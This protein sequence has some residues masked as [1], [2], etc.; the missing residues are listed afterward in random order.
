MILHGNTRGGAKQ[1]ALHLM[2]AEDN[3]YVELHDLK[4]FAA[5][6]VQ[7]AFREVQAIARGTR[8]KQFL[9]SLSL[10][11]PPSAAV[12]HS[13]FEEAIR[14]IEDQLRLSGQPRVI[15]FHE[16]EGRRHC[17]AVWSRIDAAS[18]KAINLP[19]T[20]TKLRGISQDLFQRHGWRMP[21][22]LIDHERKSTMNYTHNEHQQAKRTRQDLNAL[23]LQISKIYAASADRTDFA[24]AV[25]HKGFSLAKGDQRDFVLVDD[26]GEVY[27]LPRLA[28]NRTRDVRAKFGDNDGLPTIEE[29]H[30][31]IAKLA[32]QKKSTELARAKE[33]RQAIEKAYKEERAVLIAQHRE[34]RAKLVQ[35]QKE[36]WQ[37]ESLERASRYRKGILGLWDRMTGRHAEI[38][39]QNETEVE[40]S[41]RRDEREIAKLR[42]H[43]N[44]LLGRQ[45]I[46][47]RNHNSI[48]I[49]HQPVGHLH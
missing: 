26:N 8:C 40:F 36:R 16:K 28:C 1:L 47:L 5:N 17:H 25:E 31:R 41:K 15:V 34:E 43:Q 10:S 19:Y 37:Q 2:N 9:Y 29:A 49:A 42:H 18:M 48:N 39:A 23:K 30:R 20:K 21:K 24:A 27:S 3:E 38:R 6:D 12:D 22:G 33:Q 32:E 14:E 13:A 46:R 4:G 11:P 7:G 45:P 35:K 44:I